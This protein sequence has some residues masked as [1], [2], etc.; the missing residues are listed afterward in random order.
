[1]DRLYQA[2]KAEYEALL[3]EFAGGV[4]VTLEEVQ[5]EYVTQGVGG[6]VEI[7][8][9]WKVL[10]FVMNRGQM[11]YKVVSEPPLDLTNEA[12]ATSGTADAIDHIDGCA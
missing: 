10:S 11:L 2:P 3:L 9:D 7:V 12:E 1:M 8:R 5:D 6:G 4:I